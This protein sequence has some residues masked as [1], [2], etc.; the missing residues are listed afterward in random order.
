VTAT[1]VGYGDVSPVTAEG[2][3]I[4]VFL[5]LVGIGF[6]GLLTATLT[7]FFLQPEPSTDSVEQRLERIEIQLQQLLSHAGE[8]RSADAI[9]EHQIHR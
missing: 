4:A 3:I 6:I 2:R 5:M 8:Q 7:S 9:R 1:T